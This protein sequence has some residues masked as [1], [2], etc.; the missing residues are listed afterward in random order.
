MSASRAIMILL[1][2]A[3]F[4]A[5]LFYFGPKSM[6]RLRTRTS[7]G[8]TFPEKLWWGTVG[9][10]GTREAVISLLLFAIFF[11]LA[12]FLVNLKPQ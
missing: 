11:G 4:F 3:L 8:K 7:Q 9:W 5:I 2:V 1:A 12:V 6:D 10:I